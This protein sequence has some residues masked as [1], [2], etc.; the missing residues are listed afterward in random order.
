MSVDNCPLAAAVMTTSTGE[1]KKA[2]WLVS[3]ASLVAPGL[4]VDWIA[5]APLI[6]IATQAAMNRV[7]PAHLMC[8]DSVPAGSSRRLASLPLRAALIP[9]G[10]TS[11]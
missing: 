4:C 3:V 9:L 1:S 8:T 7:R 10:L 2:G 5:E 6:Y 11:A